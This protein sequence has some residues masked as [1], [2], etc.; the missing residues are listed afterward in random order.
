MKDLHMRERIFAKLILAH[1]TS[2]I[3]AIMDIA[4]PNPRKINAGNK[5]VN[6]CLKIDKTCKNNLLFG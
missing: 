4:L 3:K 1:T 2:Q 6:I 5:N